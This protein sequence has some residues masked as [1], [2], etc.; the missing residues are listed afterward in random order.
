M[1]RFDG[2]GVLQQFGA[3][4]DEPHR[5]QFHHVQLGFVL[6]HGK[7]HRA[8]LF[9]QEGIQL[10]DHEKLFDGGGERPDEIRREGVCETELQNGELREYLFDVLIG[11]T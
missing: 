6:N 1:L 10:F 8:D 4:R 11:D 5:V 3:E 9:F 7:P 2:D